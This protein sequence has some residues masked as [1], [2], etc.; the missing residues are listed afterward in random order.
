L[1]DRIGVKKYQALAKRVTSSH[2]DD[3][4]FVGAIFERAKLAEP[5]LDVNCVFALAETAPVLWRDR[6]VPDWW[7]LDAWAEI[8]LQLNSGVCEHC[9]GTGVYVVHCYRCDGSGTWTCAM[10]EECDGECWSCGGSGSRVYGEC[11]SCAG[12]GDWSNLWTP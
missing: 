4:T 6:G 2:D 8:V 12:L 10:H 9:D 11:F 3:V 7:D 5:V 1:Q